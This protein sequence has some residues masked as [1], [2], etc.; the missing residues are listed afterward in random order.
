MLI[1]HVQRAFWILGAVIAALLFFIG[2]ALL[3]LL[4]GPIA[5][6]PLNAAIEDS[7]NRSVTGVVVRFDQTVLELSRS[8]WKV[9]VTVLGTKILDLNGRI[10][11]QAPKAN[12]DFNAAD[13]I[14]GHLSLKRFAL[15]GVQLTGI[16]SKEGVIKLG[17]GLDQDDSDL[18]KLIREILKNNDQGGGTLDSISVRDARLAFRDEPTGLFIVSPESNFT[19]QNTN[20]RLD[21]SV[22]SMIEISGVPSHLAGHASLRDDGMPERGS[23]EVRGLSLPA[24]M[25]NNPVLAYLH[26]YQLTSDA[27]ADFVLGEHGEV[28]STNFHV[29]GAG[30]IDNASWNLPLHFDSFD[31]KGAYDG[32][33]DRFSVEDLTLRGKQISTRASGSFAV[34]W[35]QGAV[36]KVSGDVEAQD[37]SLVFPQWFRQELALSRVS[38]SGDYDQAQKKLTW[39][40][41][42]INGENLSL[43]VSGSMTFAGNQ[44]PAVALTGTMEALSVRDVLFY[45][46][47]GAAEGAY[48]WVDTHIGDGRV[49]PARIEANFPAGMLDKDEL[50][51]EVFSLSFP[52]EG[53]SARYLGDMTPLTNAHGEAKLSGDTFRAEV[54][55]GNVGPLAVSEGEVVIADLHIPSAPA[56]I[57]LHAEGE[58]TDVLEFINEEPLGYTK[59]FG[60]DPSSSSG[61]AAVDVDL[62]VPLRKDVP[63]DDIKVAVNGKVVDFSLP[64]DERRKLER[65][66]VSFAVDT[67]ALTS[68][69]SG[70]ISSVPI[71]FKWSEE[72]GAADVTTRVEV[73][74]KLDDSARAKLGFSEPTW[75]KGTMPVT[76][77]LTGKRFRF[78]DAAIK[79]DLTDATAEFKLF[80][81]E[82]RVGTRANG[83]ANIRFGEN[84]AFTVSNLVI[85]GD[86]LAARGGMTFDA[87]GKLLKA[88]ISD[89]RTGANDFAIDIE[90]TP[91]NGMNLNIQG[92]SLD[93]TKVL[94]DE[95]SKD[96]KAPAPAPPSDTD[97]VLK[98]PLVLNAKLDRLLFHPSVD[99]RDVALSVSFAANEK[100]MGLSLDA[101]GPN[102]DK[103]VGSFNVDK[104]VR[105]LSL[106]A[107]DA[108]SFV[109]TFTGFTSIKGGTLTAQISFPADSGPKAPAVD[110]LGTI[111]L[112]DIVVTDQPFLARL[113]AAGSFAGPLRLLKGEG[114]AITKF[115]APFNSRGKIVTIHEGRA[116][117]PAV[118][119]TFEG[120]LDR[121]TDH[122]ELTGTMVPAYGINSMLGAVP[123][124][125]DLLVSKKGEGVFGVTYAMKGPLEDPSLNVNPLSVLTPGILRRIFE[126]AP[127]KAPPQAAGDPAPAQP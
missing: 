121:R 34:T 103:I 78:T 4:M 47:V 111:T 28:L 83:S 20:G 69:G 108:G 87:E 84:G 6:G 36:S 26:P 82:K 88:S 41:A 76:L 79:G 112:N 110:Y 98:N 62:T 127:P 51:D 14:A 102:K 57:K 77:T 74:G 37:V 61:H 52:F 50:P 109:H 44:S 33:V 115:N 119:G 15:V 64:I 18:L 67:K 99:F 42:A 125:G 8:D 104:G 59:R 45:W 27:N 40:R 21:A 23:L 116:S 118:G 55:A 105:N 1:R 71:T 17:F 58:T 85:N 48:S 9:H 126:F 22:D 93:A 10:I 122:I 54:A 70:E 123:I 30:T 12:L 94:G 24:L 63:V 35:N 120:V 13:L 49:G 101:L 113:F 46:P 43:G 81:M 117:G 66:A 38:L 39:Q 95:K 73:A 29:T 19:V 3:R 124:L 114:I 97:V 92:K 2:G 89:L 86:G 68:Q 16:R 56:R 72:F 106:E 75:V 5:L 100:L 25:K 91:D 11:A 65:A 53:L 7:L 96:Q 90:P 60:I 80:N 31:L 107:S 32:A